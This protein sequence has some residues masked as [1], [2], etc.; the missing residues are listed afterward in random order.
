MNPLDGTMKDGESSIWVQGRWHQI[1]PRKM[2]ADDIYPPGYFRGKFEVRIPFQYLARQAELQRRT[3]ELERKLKNYEPVNMFDG[4][5]IDEWRERALK[6]ENMITRI[7][8]AS[9]LHIPD[10][11]SLDP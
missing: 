5:T 8:M 7:C 6:V 3:D 11:S 9:G 4:L 2:V 10:E 1:R